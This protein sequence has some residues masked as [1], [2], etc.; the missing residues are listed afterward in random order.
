MYTPEMSTEAF[1]SSYTKK[2]A[3]FLVLSC[4]RSHGS[5][6]VESLSRVGVPAFLSRLF[7]GLSPLQLL[8]VVQLSPQKKSLARPPSQR[9]SRCTQTALALCMCEVEHRRVPGFQRFFSLP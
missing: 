2:K 4:V 7:R 1:R 9:L 6:V 8:F 5:C 3:S